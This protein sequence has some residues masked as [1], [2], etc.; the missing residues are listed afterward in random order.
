MVEQ[1][2]MKYEEHTVMTEDGYILTMLRVNQ[3]SGGPVVLLQHGLM[4]QA[5]TWISNE[6]EVAVVF[7]LARAGYDVWLGNNRGNMYSNKHRDFDLETNPEK[8]FKYSF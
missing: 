4:S 1:Q 5:D 3:E 7:Q 2:G 8:F 6:P